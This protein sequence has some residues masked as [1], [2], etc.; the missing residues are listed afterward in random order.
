MRPLHVEAATRIVSAELKIIKIETPAETAIPLSTRRDTM[1]NARCLTVSI[2]FG[3]LLVF[4][5][6]TLRG[7][8]IVKASPKNCKVVLDNDQVRVIRV[9]LKPGEK[10]EM[11]SHQANIVYSL[12]SGKAK[13]TTADG[14]VEERELKAGQAVWSEGAT[15]STENTGTTET[16]ALLIELKE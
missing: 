1:R 6:P 10:L 16:R 2:V 8:D 9:P 3:P 12:T 13:Y 5:M 14:K 4:A 15:H 11:H 7:Q